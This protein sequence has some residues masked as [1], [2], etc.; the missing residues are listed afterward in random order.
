MFSVPS[1][2]TDNNWLQ[3]V[4][5]DDHRGHGAGAA[6]EVKIGTKNRDIAYRFGIHCTYV[7]T[8]L[9]TRLPILADA[10]KTSSFGPQGMQSWPTCPTASARHP[11]TSD[12]P[13]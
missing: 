6:H 13:G 10:A 3:K 2:S 7:S 12:E 5:K 9:T 1:P 11:R 4:P 8:I